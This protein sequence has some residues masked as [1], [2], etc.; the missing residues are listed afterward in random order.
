MELKVI[1]TA[2]KQVGKVT[3][4]DEIFNADFSSDKEALV[5]QVIVAQL[6]NKR[7]LIQFLNNY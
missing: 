2:G 4:S 1:N 5:H 6:A 3:V 7:H